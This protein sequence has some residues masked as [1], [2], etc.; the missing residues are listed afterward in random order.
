MTTRREFI[1]ILTGTV[2][3]ISLPIGLLGSGEEKVETLDAADMTWDAAT[4]SNI[5]CWHYG[6]QVTTGK[7]KLGEVLKS[8]DYENLWEN[9]SCDKCLY[10]KCRPKCL[11]ILS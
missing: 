8:E 2:I 10:S 3:A 9:P 4:G 1:K 7:Y 11:E 5:I 6:P